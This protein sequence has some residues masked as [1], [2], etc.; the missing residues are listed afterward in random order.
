MKKILVALLLVFV[1]TC[2]ICVAE[3]EVK[4]ELD[5]MGLEELLALQLEV[6]AEIYERDPLNEIVLYPGTYCVDEQIE[7]GTYIFKC[8]EIV[9]G[10]SSARVECYTRKSKDER[11]GSGHDKGSQ[12]GMQV[13]DVWQ[14]TIDDLDY[15]RINA[16]FTMIKRK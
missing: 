5:D 15:V 13:G 2:S 14:N 3:D 9:N 16:I 12:W 8:L 10:E 11:P 1:M 7:P 6:Q 4:F